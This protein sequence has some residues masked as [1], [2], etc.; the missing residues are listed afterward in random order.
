MR[1]SLRLLGLAL[2]AP[3]AVAAPP[4]VSKLS[5][6]SPGGIAGGDLSGTYPS[7]IVSQVEGVTPGAGGLAVLDDATTGDVLTTIG[8]QPLDSD[9]TAIAALSTTAYGRGLLTLGSA[10]AGQ[11]TLELELGVDVQPW[12]ADLSTYAG[13]TPGAGGTAVLDDASTLAVR[14]TLETPRM[15]TS[16]SPPTVHD[17]VDQGFRA[18]DLWTDTDSDATYVADAVADGAADWRSL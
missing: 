10:A 7:P 8:G 17:D 18:G 12:D 4:M 1:P 15:Y 6:V 3:L 9:L 16:T 11:S 13:I 2:L 5:G 14:T